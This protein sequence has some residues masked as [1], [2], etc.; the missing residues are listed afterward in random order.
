[1]HNKTSLND[2]ET[3]DAL[4]YFLSPDKSSVTD[5][6]HLSAAIKFLEKQTSDLKKV[7]KTTLNRQKSKK[8]FNPKAYPEDLGAKIEADILEIMA[9]KIVPQKRK[10]SA[11][12]DAFKYLARKAL[13]I[14]YPDLCG[15]ALLSEEKRIAHMLGKIVSRYHERNRLGNIFLDPSAIDEKN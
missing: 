11:R 8:G 2:K 6:E 15:A 7:R 4:A 9:L 5:Y 10:N 12:S 14:K 1:M 3:K 13:Q